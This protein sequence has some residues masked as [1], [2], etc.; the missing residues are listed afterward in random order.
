VFTIV[1]GRFQGTGFVVRSSA[2]HATLLTNF[3]VVQDVW[4]SG[5]RAVQVS[6]GERSFDGRILHVAKSDDLATVRVAASLPAL[7]LQTTL[8]SVGATVLVFGS[9]EGLEG[10]V[11]GGI[12][13]ALRDQYIQFSA[14]VSPGN[15][16]GPLVDSRGRVL[17]ITTAKIV[18]RG[19]EGLSFAIP[20]ETACTS[21][22]DFC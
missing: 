20:I 5:E 12:V 18:E 15:S 22:L 2:G 14:P 11:A 21:V 6:S 4:D 16:G 9:P 1:A 19:A 13:S 10:T 7:T 17:G 8:P 3:H